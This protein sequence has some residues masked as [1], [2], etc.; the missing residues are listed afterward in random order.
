MRV[1]CDFCSVG[2]S[3]NGLFLYTNGYRPADR[4]VDP[5]PR[6]GVTHADDPSNCDE[7]AA[8]AGATE[9][10][11]L[12]PTQIHVLLI[13]ANELAF[14][15]ISRM[16]NVLDTGRTD[17][18]AITASDNPKLFGRSVLGYSVLAP[19]SELSRVVHEYAVHGVRINRV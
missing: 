7:T 1:G 13:G 8:K 9:Q 18:V 11:F 15:P 3:A 10:G 12:M 6:V 16:L 5:S 19:P 14:G 4:S 2:Y 17:V